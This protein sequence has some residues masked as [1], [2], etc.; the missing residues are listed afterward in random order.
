MAVKFCRK[1]AKPYEDR[2]H[3]AIIMAFQKSPEAVLMT[4]QKQYAERYDWLCKQFKD[5]AF[6]LT[7]PFLYTTITNILTKIQRTH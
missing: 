1:V 7:T 4:F 3:L 5:L 2:T 6:N